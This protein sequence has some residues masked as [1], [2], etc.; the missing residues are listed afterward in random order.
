M[1]GPAG[2][3]AVNVHHIE[4]EIRCQA[5]DAAGTL[6]LGLC[7]GERKDAD[8]TVRLT[9]TET[10][11]VILTLTLITIVTRNRNQPLSLIVTAIL[12]QVR[13]AGTPHMPNCS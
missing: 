9:A 11:I 2:V 3:W 5:E 12:T 6:S 1:G 8:R 13:L 7:S 10:V 4:H